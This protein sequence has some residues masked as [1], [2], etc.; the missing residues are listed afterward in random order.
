M[1]RYYIDPIKRKVVALFMNTND[2]RA[3]KSKQAIENALFKLLDN[4]DFSKI[5]I[6]DICQTA[7]IGR[8][9]FYRHYEDKY[10]LL[11]ELLAKYT[12]IFE[13]LLSERMTDINNV[14]L[15]T[16]LHQGLKEHTY[17]LICLFDNPLTHDQCLETRFTQLL[18]T[19]L[20]SYLKRR[21]LP[22]LD[23]YFSQLYAQ[24]VLHNIKW[25]LRYG[26]DPK[27]IATTNTMFNQLLK[28]YIGTK[29][30]K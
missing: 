22:Q 24:S 28:Y 19:H 5:S 1:V 15:L 26:I 4:K 25:S 11:N 2:L 20:Q 30:V 13:Q 7:M 14:D 10:V 12:H 21:K 27:L 16:Q 3:L 8:S 23:P 29:K 17:A 18:V 9:T 6:N